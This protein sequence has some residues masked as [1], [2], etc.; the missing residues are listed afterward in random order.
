MNTTQI[1]TYTAYITYDINTII[2]SLN[3]LPILFNLH[4][5]SEKMACIVIAVKRLEI[6]TETKQSN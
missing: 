6:N 1:R 4:M 5:N 2:H 3:T